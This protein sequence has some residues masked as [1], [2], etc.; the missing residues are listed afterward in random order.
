MG[1]GVDIRRDHMCLTVASYSFLSLERMVATST[2]HG[3]GTFGRYGFLF[4]LRG[5]CCGCLS[6]DGEGAG[7]LDGF[8]SRWPCGHDT[9]AHHV[10]SRRL[11]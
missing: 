8:V 5:T 3:V 2:G 9:V 7:L 10:L 1:L 11:S 4:V 6:R